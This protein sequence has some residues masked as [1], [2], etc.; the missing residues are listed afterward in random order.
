[1]SKIAGFVVTAADVRHV[2][3]DLSR[4]ECVLAEAD[5]T[6]WV[7]DDRS[8]VLR[9]DPDGRQTRIGEVGGLPN[10]LAMDRLGR[11][12]VAD[13]E[14]GKLFRLSRD[15]RHELLLDELDGARL[16][17]LNFVYL[18]HEARLWATVSTRVEPRSK[19]AHSQIPDGS[20][21]R[22]DAAGWRSVADGFRFTNE[23]RLDAGGKYLYVAETASGS[24]CRLPLLP[25][26]SLGP[27]EPFGPEPLAPGARTDGIAFDSQANLWVTDVARNALFVIAPDGEATE[28]FRDPEGTVMPAPTSIAFSG[29][30]LRTVLVGSLT[31]TRLVSFVSPVAGEPLA[32]WRR[33]G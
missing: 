25:D 29:P 31:A 18:D 2:G 20:I 3:H 21:L 23:I 15:G 32:H 26:G 1:M 7:S 14:R 11:L 6:L 5:G 22:L 27:R 30:D 17:A 8:A 28:V 33:G 16:G 24:V 12:Y 10:G 4:P 13:I 9:I 19:A